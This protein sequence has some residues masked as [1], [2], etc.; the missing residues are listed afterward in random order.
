MT[1]KIEE[2][3][4]TLENGEN[5]RQ[6]LA[7]LRQEIKIEDQW[8]KAKELLEKTKLLTEFLENEDAKTRKNAALLLGDFG[9]QPALSELFDSYCREKTLFVKPSYLTAIAGMN[10]S[11]LDLELT[12]RYEELA[13][14]TPLE[15]EKK[16]IAE[17]LRELSKMMICL[18]GVK[19]HTFTELKM[20]HELILTTNRA[21]REVT[22]KQIRTGKTKLVATGVMVKTDRLEPLLELRTYRELLFP[23]NIKSIP[24]EDG[25]A[26]GKLLANSNLVEFLEECH[27][28]PAPFFFRLEIKGKLPLDKKSSLAK[29]MA[30]SLEQESKRKLLNSTSDYEVEIR[31]IETKDGDFHPYLK[32]NTIPMK[33]YIYRKNVVASSIQP[34]SV[35]LLVKL[36]EPY[37]KADAQI[38]DPFCGVGTMLIERNILVPAREMY[39]TDIFGEAIK[40]ARENAE[41]AGVRINYIN[42]DYFDF[43]HEYLFDEIITNMPV[44]GRKTREEQDL[45][46]SS[47]FEKS[48]KLLTGDGVIIMYSNENGFVKKQLRI[49]KEYH[50]LSEYVIREKEGYYLFIIGVRGNERCH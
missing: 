50:L 12:E 2:I 11:A 28:E 8:S 1:D 6:N 24:S 42:R 36:A 43:T 9:M 34:S 22:E 40:K 21:Y 29:R 16:H 39:G 25:V 48:L 31:L 33:R 10:Y 23:L 35:A 37:L 3:V 47:F 45:F 41:L 15:E 38:M 4:K 17:E 44:R 49:H 27:K 14:Y 20:V 13:E 5:I 46:Y 18:H 32:M 30:A 19:K 26:A 7:Q